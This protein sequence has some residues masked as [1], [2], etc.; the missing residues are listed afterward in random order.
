MTYYDHGKVKKLGDHRILGL[1]QI[2]RYNNRPKIKNENVAEHSFYVI[3]NVLKIC[4]M[5]NI[6][7]E[8]KYKALEF[9]AVHDIPELLTGDT[10]YD[11]KVNNPDLNDLLQEVEVRELERQM[12]EYLD[13][14]KEFLEAEKKET[15]PFLITKLADAASVLQYSNLEI[16]LGNNTFDMRRI[17]EDAKRRVGTLIEQ[18][19]IKLREK[20][21]EEG[22][23]NEI[24]RSIQ[25]FL[26]KN[27]QH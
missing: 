1:G 21:R 27:E 7:D 26:S 13:A 17:N 24:R 23:F 11:T 10:P 5:F 3:L 14:Y 16:K 20:R 19:E 12:P 4:K 15:I 22:D 9:A 18:L 8:T 25:D 2:I 6:D